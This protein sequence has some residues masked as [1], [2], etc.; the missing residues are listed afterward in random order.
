MRSNLSLASDPAT[1]T[2]VALRLAAEF[3]PTR[4]VVRAAVAARPD[5]S[6]DDQLNFV[7]DRDP[8][9]RKAAASNPA[10]H[11]RALAVFVVSP[12]LQRGTGSAVS[13]RV[14]AMEPRRKAAFKELCDGI[15]EGRPECRRVGW[16]DDVEARIRGVWKLFD[17]EQE[18]ALARHESSKSRS[19]VGR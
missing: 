11:D 18:C 2:S 19:S 10:L 9:V 7:F 12:H 8:D 1:P 3:G 16:N 15:R 6:I 13:G 17:K 4:N 14:A 5:L